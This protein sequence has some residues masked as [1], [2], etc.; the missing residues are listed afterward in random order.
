MCKGDRQQFARESLVDYSDAGLISDN[1][2]E[3][4]AIDET[5]DLDHA[6]VERITHIT[7]I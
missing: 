4:A 7:A 2:C 5:T 6:V 3:L 1:R